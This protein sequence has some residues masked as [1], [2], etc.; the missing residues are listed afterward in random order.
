MFKWE[1]LEDSYY[2]KALTEEKVKQL[3]EHYRKYT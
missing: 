3:L 1:P 2:K